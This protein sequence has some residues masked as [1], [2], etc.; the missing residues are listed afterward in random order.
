MF[1]IRDHVCEVR[2][3]SS[4]CLAPLFPASAP[5]ITAVREYPHSRAQDRATMRPAFFGRGRGASQ[6]SRS[7][8]GELAIVRVASVYAP[9]KDLRHGR[10]RMLGFVA[11]AARRRENLRGALRSGKC[12]IGCRA[13][14]ARR[15]S[16]G[17]SDMVVSCFCAWFYGK[18]RAN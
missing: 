7:R 18:R 12:I 14:W 11:T 16:V 4:R 3:R 15:T 10:A 13:C 5:V 2:P 8:S 17:R 6:P 1:A 9:G